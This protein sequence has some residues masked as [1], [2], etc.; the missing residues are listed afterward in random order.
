MS[1]TKTSFKKIVTYVLFCTSFSMQAQNITT[2][3]VNVSAIRLKE[4]EY[5]ATPMQSF[6]KEDFERMG[7]SGVS[8]AIKH[9][10]GVQVKDYGGIGG[11]KTVSIRGLGSQHT[12]VTYDGVAVSDC[13]TGQVDISRYAIDNVKGL[14]LTI[15]QGDD[16]FQSATQLASAGVLNINTL[17]LSSQSL[18]SFRTGSY[19]LVNPT[20]LYRTYINNVLHISAYVDYLRADGNYKFHM[21]N[22]T[23]SI[24][25]KRNNSDI[26]TWKGEI[27]LNYL[28]TD[29]QTLKLKAYLF[30]SDRG[31]PGNVVY[32]NTYAAE[33]SHDKN[34]FG[35]LGYENKFSEKWKLCANAKFNWS[36]SRY[37]D[38][39]IASETD[40]RFRQTEV[41]ANAV[42]WTQPLKELSFSMAQDFKY[43]YLHTSLSNCPFPSR[44]TVLSAIAGHYTNEWV[45]ATASLLNTYITEEVKVGTA[46][47]DRHR[48]SPAMSISVKPIRG[49]NWRLRASYKD[50]FRNP[51][52]NDLYYTQVGNRSL[53]P[54]KTRQFNVGTLLSQSFNC[55]VKYVNISVDTYYGRVNDNIVAIPKMF[56]WSM[57]NV[58]KVEIKGIDATLNIEGKIGN[59]VNLNV[60][61]TYNYMQALD[62][63]DKNSSLW[64]NQLPYTPK[65]SGSASMTIENSIINITYN[66]IWTSERYYMQQNSSNTRIAPYSDHSISL[67]RKFNIG[68]NKL[69]LQADALNIGD[70]NYEVVRFYPMPG[71]NYKFTITYIF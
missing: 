4:S 69:K 47:A 61:A 10:S 14:T 23:K 40:N 56:F 29:K 34:Y 6:G 19:G 36:W 46:A 70:K 60:M 1:I 66:L 16:I 37:T 58:G 45:S 50:I 26:D 53:N 43:N 35:Q 38:K 51:T 32:D 39:D 8:D 25:E 57:F 64:H 48:L 42:L 9:M 15:G 33:R 44:Y 11:L 28:P 24:D 12:A 17:T 21:M 27:S 54:E 71:Q 59:Y 2:D 63:T 49:I 3:T 5:S 7:T 68:K 62:I 30:D 41:Y 65:Q 13:Q 52:F 67:Y 20:L 31:L 55:I 18:A 22:G